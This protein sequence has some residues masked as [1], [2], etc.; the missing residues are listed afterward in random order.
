MNFP[1]VE[2]LMQWVYLFAL[3]SVLLVP[4]F[5][6]REIALNRGK[7]GRTLFFSGL[8]VGLLSLIVAILIIKAISLIIKQEGSS[9]FL[10]YLIIIVGHGLAYWAVVRAKK[11]I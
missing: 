5:R 10:A 3:I 2:F 6:L 7:K 9:Y 8:G 4:A 1:Y 11:R